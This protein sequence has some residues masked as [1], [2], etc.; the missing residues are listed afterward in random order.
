MNSEILKTR[1]FDNNP[2]DYYKFTLF[3]INIAGPDKVDEIDII[4][5][6]LYQLYNRGNKK[7]SKVFTPV[8]IQ[9]S[10]NTVLDCGACPLKSQHIRRYGRD[11]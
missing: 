4:N 6:S 11:H 2:L 10:G 5:V 9:Q 3:I 8:D 1:P 7:F